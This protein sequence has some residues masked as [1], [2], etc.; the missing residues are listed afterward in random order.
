MNENKSTFNPPELINSFRDFSQ[1]TRPWKTIIFIPGLPNAT[2]G[3]VRYSLDEGK[4]SQSLPVV[5]MYDRPDGTGSYWL[6]NHPLPANV[7]LET[8]S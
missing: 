2:A 7:C 4:T 3:I 5:K 6:S 1:P 8:V